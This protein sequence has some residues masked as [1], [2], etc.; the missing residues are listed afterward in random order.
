[1]VISLYIQLH[2]ILSLIVVKV[3]ALPL[4]KS[5][6]K[7]NESSDLVAD[8]VTP[9]ASVTANGSQSNMRVLPYNMSTILQKQKGISTSLFHRV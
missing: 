2:F 5:C 3:S 6:R 9:F 7:N 8:E 1:M 4:K